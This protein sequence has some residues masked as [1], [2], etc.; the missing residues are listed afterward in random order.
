YLLNLSNTLSKADHSP[1][2][3]NITAPTGTITTIRN[4]IIS[5]PNILPS[6]LFESFC[7]LYSS[8]YEQNFLLHIYSSRHRK[9]SSIQTAYI[10]QGRSYTFVRQL[11]GISVQK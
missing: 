2:T 4:T 9:Y 8:Y 5:Q 6:R 3:T 1:D 10:L 7:I 11:A